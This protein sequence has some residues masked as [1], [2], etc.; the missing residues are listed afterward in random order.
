MSDN[1]FGEAREAENTPRVKAIWRPYPV[2]F[3]ECELNGRLH[4][5]I[6]FAEQNYAPVIFTGEDGTF[7]NADEYGGLTVEEATELQKIVFADVIEGF[8]RQI[9][10]ARELGK[11]ATMDDYVLACDAEGILPLISKGAMP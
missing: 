4:Q 9:V 10:V 11:S 6:A 5:A 7:E 3:I 8:R 2:N 1:V